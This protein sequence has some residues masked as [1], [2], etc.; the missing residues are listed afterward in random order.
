MPL[1]RTTSSTIPVCPHCLNRRHLRTSESWGW[2]RCSCL[3]GVVT[4]QYIKPSLR[5]TP[6]EDAYPPALDA[7]PPI[8]FAPLVQVHRGK[9]D[10]FRRMAWRTLSEHEPTGFSYDVMTV[11]RLNDIEFS[12]ET[13]SIGYESLSHLV[14][15]HLLILTMTPA[16]PA[17]RWIGYTLAHILELRAE[18]GLPTWIFT[19][20]TGNALSTV[21][22][23]ADEGVRESLRE[24]LAYQTMVEWK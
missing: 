22:A 8:P 14:G 9:W 6:P 24:T 19:F 5:G 13:G 11:S 12:R 10:T 7:T 21:Y 3:R 1:P 18:A 20:L 15:L 23:Q 4:Q 16:T 2:T 17:H